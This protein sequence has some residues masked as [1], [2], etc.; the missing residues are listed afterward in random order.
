VPIDLLIR[1]SDAAARRFRAAGVW[2]D[3]GQMTELRRWRDETPDAPAIKA[4]RADGDATLIS[5]AEL[6]RH[7]ERFAGALYE[8]G[9]RPGQVVAC[10]LPNWWQAQALLLAATRLEAVL[11]PIMTTIR[12]RELERVLHRLGASV[13]V[14]ADEWAGFGHAAALR[15]IAPRLSEL[16]HRVVM[17]EPGDGEI[18]FR[19]FF[20][21]TPWEQ[22]HP[23]ALDDARED[24]D[25]VALVLFTS[26]TSGEPKAALHTQN[27]MFASA[28]GGGKVHDFG[29]HDVRFISHALMHIVG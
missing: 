3:S 8:L 29:R 9:V 26:G 10:Q 18:D 23:V 15:E 28:I 13:C 2:R 16:R 21:E 25:R 11:A 19:S 12:P 22:R 6:A 27:T 14:T 24:P 4:Y 20:E 17:G 1:P 7:V 5:Y